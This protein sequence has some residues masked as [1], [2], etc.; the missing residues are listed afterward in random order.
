MVLTLLSIS[1]VG[2]VKFDVTEA[3]K[4]FLDGTPLPISFTAPTIVLIPKVKNPTH[5]SEF[6]PISL[7]NTS[8]KILTKLL[9]DHIKLILPELITSNHSGFVPKRLIGDNILLA[10]EIMHSIAANKIDWNVVLKLDMAKAYIPIGFF[11]THFMEVGFSGRIIVLIQNC[12]NN[13]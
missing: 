3:A 6:R 11:G 10:Q 12:T 4:D 8:N 1:A 9:N 7:C 5:W 13:Y 2:I